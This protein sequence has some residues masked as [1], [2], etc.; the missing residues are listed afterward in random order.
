[1]GETVEIDPKQISDWMY[2]ENGKLRGGK[3]MILLI[4]RMPEDQRKA[5]KKALGI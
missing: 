3:T 4:N 2:F 5:Y 1:M